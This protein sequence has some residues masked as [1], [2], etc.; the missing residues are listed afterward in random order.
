MGFISRAKQSTAEQ[1]RIT[2]LN[3][4]GQDVRYEG[5]PFFRTDQYGKRFDY[6]VCVRRSSRPRQAGSDKLRCVT[7]QL[8]VTSTLEWAISRRRLYVVFQPIVRL[9]DNECEGVKALV[10][11]TLNGRTISPEVF[12]RIA[13][14]DHLI[15][16]L[17]DLVLENTL[18]QLGRL[19]AANPSFYVSI[20]VSSE[21][22]CTFRFLNLLTKSLTGTGITPR[23][24]RIEATERSFMNADTTRGVVAAFRAAAPSNL[25]RRLWDRLLESLLS[26]NL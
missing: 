14:E 3:M 22:L 4:L 18:A 1:A 6:L 21:D 25:H 23:Q 8:S 19:L 5:A 15:Q 16:P 17:T 26:A 13:E 10:R 11:W 24:I 20:N 2:A 9:A 12:V 7:R